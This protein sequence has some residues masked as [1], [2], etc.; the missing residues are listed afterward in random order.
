M[1][2][3][4]TLLFL[5]LGLLCLGLLIHRTGPAVLLDN[6]KHIGWGV[7]LVIAVELVVDALNTR[8]WQHTLPTSARIVPFF[9]SKRSPC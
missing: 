8:G 4:L 9:S 5:I 3:K 2:N 6:L 7:A 1:K